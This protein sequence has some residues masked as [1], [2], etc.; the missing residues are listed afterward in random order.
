[1]FH[2]NRINVSRLKHYSP[3]H[4]L[5]FALVVPT[6]DGWNCWRL[7]EIQDRGTQC[8]CHRTLSHLH[9]WA[10]LSTF[11]DEWPSKGGTWSTNAECACV[12]SA[13]WIFRTLRTALNTSEVWDELAALFKWHHFYLKRQLTNCGYSDLCV[14][15]TFFLENEWRCQ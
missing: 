12:R 10:H 5:T 2:I 4:C 8:G 9:Q 6:K 15:L 1:M 11:C 3:L 7:S 13:I 14:W